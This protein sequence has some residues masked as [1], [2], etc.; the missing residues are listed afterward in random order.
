[1]LLVDDGL[2]TGSTMRAAIRAVRT[3]MPAA[4]VVAVP[5]APARTCDE[6]RD[7]AEE[8]VCC[9]VPHEF[10]AIGEHYDRFGQVSDNEVQALLGA[11]ASERD[12]YKPSL[13]AR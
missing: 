4:V 3:R 12:Q 7:I 11:A 1:V 8:V 5:V 2:A 6:L 10:L 9:Y 13:A